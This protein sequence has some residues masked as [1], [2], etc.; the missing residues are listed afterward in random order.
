M[1]GI[2]GIYRFDQKRKISENNI[3]DTLTA[4]QS[5]GRD[6]T[7]VAWLTDKTYSILKTSSDASTFVELK[8]F[9]ESLPKILQSKVVLLHTRAATH[10]SPFNNLNNH[11]LWNNEGLI[12][13]NGVVTPPLNL[14]SRGETDSEQIMLYIQKYGL[15][16]GIE[17]LRGW[18]AIA[19][20]DFRNGGLTL[21]RDGAPIEYFVDRTSLVFGS[22][23]EI[24]KKFG[25]TNT[26]SLP[27]NFAYK[28]NG[29][30]NPDVV[31]KIETKSYVYYNQTPGYYGYG[32]G[33]D[34]EGGGFYANRGASIV[35]SATSPT[36]NISTPT[37]KESKGEETVENLEETLK[38][39][40]GENQA[41]PRDLRDGSVQ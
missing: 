17:K 12:I 21:F 28:F 37:V 5:R 39:L 14:P 29:T 26:W 6:A 1:C 34:D 16:N 32:Y 31:G 13:H 25:V 40:E 36:T 9:K 7:G 10:G 35:K 20:V 23:K 2:A 18:L 8:E 38:T 15:K 30:R 22:T 33:F 27:E 19:Y 41:W 4:L 24:T 3:V 11:P